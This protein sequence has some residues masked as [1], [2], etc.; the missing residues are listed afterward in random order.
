M[1]SNISETDDGQIGQEVSF[2]AVDDGTLTTR[3]DADT[4]VATMS[5]GHGIITGDIVNVYWASGGERRGM[6][7]TVVGDAVTIDGGLGDDLPSQDDAVEL[8]V[9]VVIDMDFVGNLLIMLA[10]MS[11]TSSAHVNMLD[12]GDAEL[13]E[14]DLTV[15]EAYTW[16][17]GNGFTNPLASDTVAKVLVA[18][19]TGVTAAGTGK[20]G[21][22]YNSAS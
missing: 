16:S 18:A 19:A 11:E 12:S 1:T 15:N 10:M 20:I 7:A 4:G 2:D 22:L 13:L 5:S 6:D 14:V 17:S 8:A 9:C 21:I 3:T